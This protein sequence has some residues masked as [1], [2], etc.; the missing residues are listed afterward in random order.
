MKYEFVV[1]DILFE[2]IFQHSGQGRSSQIQAGIAGGLRLSGNQYVKRLRIAFESAAVVCPSDRAWRLTSA[3]R[4]PASAR[5]R[6]R[7]AD[8]PRSCASAAASAS[9]G[10]QAALRAEAAPSRDYA[11]WPLRFATPR[12][13]VSGACDKNP[14]ARFQ[15]P[16]F[17]PGAFEKPS[18]AEFGPDLSP[19]PD[20][21]PWERLD[22]PRIVAAIILL[23]RASLQ[24][25]YGGLNLQS[26]SINFAPDRDIR[27]SEEYRRNVRGHAGL[28]KPG[29]LPVRLWP[30]RRHRHWADTPL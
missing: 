21:G 23:G 7:K 5:R 14:P 10:D 16:G 9:S 22:S 25:G 2:R 19:W 17:S 1:S 20:D 30:A 4:R 3:C 18:C 13:C 26:Q 29:N 6:A 15:K 28:C 8:G 27:I 12:C 24:V 11:Q